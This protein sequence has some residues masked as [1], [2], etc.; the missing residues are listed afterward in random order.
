MVDQDGK[1]ST[2]F[3]NTANNLR[4]IRRFI[5]SDFD[6]NKKLEFLK[7]FFREQNEIQDQDIE[8]FYRLWNQT[9]KI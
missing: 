9:Y 6:I 3:V 7:Y 8:C 2:N 1:I 4:F 5:D